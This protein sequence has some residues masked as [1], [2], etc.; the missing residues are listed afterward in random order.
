MA[1]SK[2][3]KIETKWMHC[4]VDN[5]LK[6]KRYIR[7]H[8]TISSGAAILW[9]YSHGQLNDIYGLFLDLVRLLI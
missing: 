3:A 2:L 5:E 6:S 9:G 8:L 4:I 7:V 1:Q